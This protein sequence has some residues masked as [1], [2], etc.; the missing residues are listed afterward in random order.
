VTGAAA[1]SRRVGAA[2]PTGVVC[3]VTLA[4]M[5]SSANALNRGK[6]MVDEFICKSFMTV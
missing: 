6:F 5:A 1:A 4:D 3:A 2:T